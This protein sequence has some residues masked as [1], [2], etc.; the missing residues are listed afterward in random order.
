MRIAFFLHEFPALSQTFILNQI[1]GMM[2]RG[3]EV[4][5][6]ATRR[7]RVEKTH[8]QVESYGLLN[9]TRFI[10][11]VPRGYLERLTIAIGLGLR[12]GL[13]RRPA[14]VFR[15]IALSDSGRT[16]LSLRVLYQVLA[17]ADR[18][19]YDVIHCQFGTLGLLALRL[20][21][22]GALDGVLV[23][24]FR[25]FDVNRVL[26]K[27]PSCY[28]ELFRCG[29]LHLP[30][31][32]SLADRLMA[33]GCPPDRMKV[34]HSGIDCR[35][36][37]F[38]ERRRDGEETIRVLGIGRFVRKKGWGD[39]IEAVAKAREGGCD[40]RFS[41]VGDG[42]L[43]HELE[44]KI[45]EC[46]LE[47]SV[48]LLGWCDHDEVARLLDESHI[49]IAPSVTA[50]DGDQEGIPNVLK[51][52]MATGLPVLSTWHSGIPELVENGLSGYL[53][54]ER[55]VGALAERLIS[56]CAH[57]ERWGAM[58]RAGRK[59]IEAEFDTEQINSELERLYIGAIENGAQHSV[60]VPTES[61]P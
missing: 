3:H 40:I 33:A 37:R 55:D 16:G 42:E 43:R 21:R 61:I 1:T 47:H 38:S 7:A 48:A 58:G 25:G 4:D 26:T 51:E 9:K 56:L 10:S 53:V 46:R 57:P 35:R 41:M 17:L 24:S 19:N 6:Y 8:T 34:V 2:D 59:K 28:D 36:F 39:A 54:A 20:K 5:V 22:L 50:A 30:V 23:T 45:A 18:P 27:K 15:A 32:R 52:A 29:D 60:A 12:R 49:L 11:E 14:Q 44:Q 13:W 31:S